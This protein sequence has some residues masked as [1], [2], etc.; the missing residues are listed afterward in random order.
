M[1]VASPQLII[2]VLQS[3]PWV[4][5]FALTEKGIKTRILLAFEPNYRVYQSAIA[6]ALRGHRPHLDVKTA[7]PE[8]FEVKMAHFNPHLVIFSPPNKVPPDSRPAWVEFYSLEPEVWA[9]ICLDGTLSESENP[10]LNELLSIV[11]ETERLARTTRD[12]G[13]C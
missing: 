12:L 5:C 8:T 1:K 11:D 4:L 7:E 9:A 2:S 3:R 6:H 13:N 10:G